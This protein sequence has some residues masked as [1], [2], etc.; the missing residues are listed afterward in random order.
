MLF[1]CGYIEEMGS[2]METCELLGGYVYHDRSPKPLLSR[3]RESLHGLLWMPEQ[4]GRFTTGRHLLRP[5]V[6][7]TT[8]ALGTLGFVCACLSIGTSR[9]WDAYAGAEQNHQDAYL[10]LLQH[11]NRLLDQYARV[12]GIHHDL[13]AAI[14][15]ISAAEGID[16]ELAFRLVRVESN[17]RQYAK[18]SA[19]AL[20]YTQLMPHT[21]R[22]LDPSI[23][24]ESE[25]YDR[26]TNLR[27]GFRYLR[28]L[29]EQY[30]D[31]HLALLAYNRGP[32]RVNRLLSIGKDP[33]NGYA[34]RV[35]GPYASPSGAPYE[36]TG[37]V[38]E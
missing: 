30:G 37:L 10:E 24:T 20:G 2:K 28:S 38:G 21:A 17:F 33:S 4:M 29:I 32:N 27:L 13:A 35:L 6:K 25:I 19:G 16:P 36:G 9:H 34:R 15:D 5:W 11:R 1:D 14:Y 3:T 8:V 22:F 18:S 26:D 31:L 23:D 7:K 12:Y